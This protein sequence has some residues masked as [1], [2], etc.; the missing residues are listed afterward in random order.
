MI[1]QLRPTESL[2]V[3]SL[4]Q[5]Q[6]RK[7]LRYWGYIYIYIVYI[8]YILYVY[9]IQSNYFHKTKLSVDTGSILLI[10]KGNT[11]F[12]RSDLIVRVVW[13]IFLYHPAATSLNTNTHRAAVTGGFLWWRWRGWRASSG[14]SFLSAC[15]PS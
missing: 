2:H 9:H 4:N 10:N 11:S 5:M 14:V 3:M 1:F 8:S 15:L 7:E 12:W 6:V 13:S